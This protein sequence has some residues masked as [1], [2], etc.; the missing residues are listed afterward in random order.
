MHDGGGEPV[1]LLREGSVGPGNVPKK[2]KRKKEAKAGWKIRWQKRKNPNTEHI[3]VPTSTP[4]SFT[5]LSK[6]RKRP[7]YATPFKRAAGAGCRTL[8]SGW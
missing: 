2:A 8:P 4:V 3:L 7:P 1:G 6:G 5:R